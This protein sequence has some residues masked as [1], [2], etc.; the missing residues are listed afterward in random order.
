MKTAVAIAVILVVLSSIP[1][2][3]QQPSA[4]AQTSASASASG[5]SI[6]QSTSA[7]ASASANRN[8]SR[9]AGDA[10]ASGFASMQPVQGELVGHLDSKNAKVGDKV[11]VKT[12]E[13]LKTAEGMTIPKGSKLIGHVSEVKAHG[14]G[15]AASRLGIV[16]DQAE[17]KGGSSMAIHAVI[18]SVAPSESALAAAQRDR[19]DEMSAMNGGMVGGRPMG[20]AHVGGGLIGGGVGGATAATAGLGSGFRSTTGEAL[21]TTGSLTG[22][23]N[24]RVGNSLNASANAANGLGAHASTLPGIAL[25]SGTSSSTSGVLTASKRNVHLDS[26]TQMTLGVVG[27]VS[28]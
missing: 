8:G 20:A 25:E 11:V 14:S 23:A 19:N 16:F 28:R 12:T 24:T 3:G 15:N 10:N 7:N 13:S 17:I 9:S 26:G 22:E 18:E 6:S 1:I 27:A 21:G 4:E 2:F 5:S